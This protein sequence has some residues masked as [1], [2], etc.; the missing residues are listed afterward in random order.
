MIKKIFQ[1]RICLKIV[2]KNAKLKHLKLCLIYLTTYGS[3][4][5]KNYFSVLKKSY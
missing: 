3:I 5:L 2:I 4:P 1:L